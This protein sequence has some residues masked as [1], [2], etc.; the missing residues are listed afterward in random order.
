LPDYWG[1]FFEYEK[2]TI[3]YSITEAELLKLIDEERLKPKP[4]IDSK[5]FISNVLTNLGP[6]HTFHRQFS[7]RHPDLQRERVLGMQLYKIMID[8]KDTWYYCET[9][10]QGHVFPNATYFPDK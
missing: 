8:Q 6:R 7:E 2:D 5:V 3:L 4:Y 1:S 9:H 10:H